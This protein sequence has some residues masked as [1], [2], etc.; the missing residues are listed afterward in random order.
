MTASNVQVFNFEEDS[1]FHGELNAKY[2]DLPV[3]FFES[4]ALSL[5]QY[6]RRFIAVVANSSFSTSVI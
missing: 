5:C 4:F 1:V 6:L 3:K 2:L